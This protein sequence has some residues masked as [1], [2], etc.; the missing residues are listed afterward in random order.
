[1][2]MLMRRISFFE[3]GSS[4]TKAKWPF[5]GLSSAFQFGVGF[6]DGFQIG[7]CR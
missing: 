5:L 3:I 4:G 1:M 2:G 7:V 6:A